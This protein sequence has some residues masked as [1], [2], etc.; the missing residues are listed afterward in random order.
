MSKIQH[1]SLYKLRASSIA[2]VYPLVTKL[3]YEPEMQPAGKN[4]CFAAGSS[5]NDGEAI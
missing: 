5:G 4:T 3:A 1:A 2:Q